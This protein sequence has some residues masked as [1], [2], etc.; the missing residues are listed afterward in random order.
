M[1]SLVLRF[2][3]SA[4]VC[5]PV[6]IPALAGVVNDAGVSA[7]TAYRLVPAPTTFDETDKWMSIPVGRS[8]RTTG[9]T[10]ATLKL[11]SGNDRVFPPRTVVFA[12]NETLNDVR[13]YIEDFWYSGD[14][15]VK[16]ELFDGDRIADTSSVAI[17]EDEAPPQTWLY[18]G[19]AREGNPKNGVPFT[20]HVS[21]PSGT[22]VRLHLHARSG[23]AMNGVD[24]PPFDTTVEIPRATSVYEINV[25][26]SNDAE[27]EK[28]ENFFVDIVNAEGATIW[29]PYTPA[30]IEDDDTV[31]LE[32]E[33]L[34]LNGTL[35]TI[36]VQLPSAA[37]F[38]DSIQFLADPTILEGPLMIPVPKGARTISWQAMA[39][40]AGDVSFAIGT[41]S[42]LPPARLNAT[43][44]IFDAHT[45]TLSPATLQLAPGGS[46]RVT[47]TVDPP[48]AGFSF[49]SDR[50]VAALETSQPVDGKPTFLVHGVGPGRTEIV[51]TLTASA[52]GAVARLPVIV[53]EP[54]VP[55][56]RIR[57]VR[58]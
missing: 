53:K 36:S 23:T 18:G 57:G 5:A 54:F 34:V 37:P 46:A 2:V 21:P 8:G 7:E 19:T 14:T 48:D 39:K 42:F 58:H 15:I 3:L 35:T 56:T 32:N 27:V 17:L 9:A 40:R 33:P 41:P 12:P 49:R 50:T 13:F 10:H 24:F 16:V 11:T 44:T 1:R 43:M 55:A 29:T 52:G 45:V 38:Q 51:L 26:I 31:Y 20:L 47:V 28:T 25:P 30:S 6:A 22:P 4:L